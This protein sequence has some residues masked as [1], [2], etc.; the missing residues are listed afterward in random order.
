L[1]LT[2]IIALPGGKQR[3]SMDGY[4]L[5]SEFKNGI[6]YL[7]CQKPTDIELSLLPHIIMTSDVT[8]D[9][10]L[11]DNMNDNIDKVYNPLEDTPENEYNFD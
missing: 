8:W 7:H 2:S 5:P 4:H 6:P 10:S 9:P 3:I 1:V 11:Y